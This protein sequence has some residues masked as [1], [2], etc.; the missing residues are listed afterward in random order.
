M[1]TIYNYQR[2]YPIHTGRLHQDIIRILAHLGRADDDIS[3]WITT[4]RTIRRYNA[5]F[6]HKDKATDI[7][8]F[9]R[10]DM[11]L[12]THCQGVVAYEDRALGDIII[13]AAA[14]A[15]QAQEL[16]VS[17][18]HRLRRLVVHGICHLLGYDHQTE[19][20]YRVMRACEQKLMAVCGDQLPVYE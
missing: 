19:K 13:S 14:V 6:R 12:D 5:V 1:I 16:D 18:M 17:Y 20:A 4:D 11:E 10:Y 2:T 15:R 3:L 7:L 9:P 8:S